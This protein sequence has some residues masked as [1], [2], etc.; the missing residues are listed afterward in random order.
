MYVIEGQDAA[1]ARGAQMWASS[2][3]DVSTASRRWSVRLSG[4]CRWKAG[5]P[6]SDLVRQGDV[7][8]ETSAESAD[9]RSP[10]IEAE[11]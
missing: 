10:S 4:G 6:T 8:R 3:N 9:A 5:T 2:A 7:P 11:T 1:H